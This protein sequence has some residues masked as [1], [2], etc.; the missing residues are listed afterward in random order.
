MC[1]GIKVILNFVSEEIDGDFKLDS[2]C[3]WVC[4][5]EYSEPFTRDN[6]QNVHATKRCGWYGRES[7][8]QW[9]RKA[10]TAVGSKVGGRRRKSA[11]RFAN[12]KESFGIIV[13]YSLQI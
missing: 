4:T 12:A 1:L 13:K 3:V 10:A 7:T 5:K 8:S 6:I 9:S 2:S 11:S